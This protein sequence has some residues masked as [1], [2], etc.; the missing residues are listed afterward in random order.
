MMSNLK[1]TKKVILEAVFEDR[2]PVE[3]FFRSFVLQQN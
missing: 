3:K 1:E 2:S